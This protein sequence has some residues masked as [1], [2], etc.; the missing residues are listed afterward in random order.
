[1]TPA[2]KAFIQLMIVLLIWASSFTITRSVVKDVPPI[3]FALLRYSVASIVMVCIYYSQRSKIKPPATKMHG[4][5]LLMAL[6]GISLYY[7]FFNISL[8]HTEAS[9]GALI[10]GFIPVVVM[11]LAY[12][13]LKEK[14]SLRQV[15]GSVICLAGVILIGFI[16]PGK[17][18]GNSLFGNLLMIAAVIC[19]AVYTILS[20]RVAQT[21]SIWLTTRLTVIGTILL[22]PAV[23]IEMW[24]QPLPQI[25]AT[26]WAA[27]I[28]MGIF[29]SAISYLWYNNALKH[30]S[31][32]RVGLLLNLD[33][34]FGA[35]LAVVV[36][37]EPLYSLQIVGA[38]LVFAGILLSSSKKSA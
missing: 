29:P 27:I 9:V 15:F 11:I 3:L 1:M 16:S 5:V 33:P 21:D 17:S 35:V 37:N 23:L 28:Y 20:K 34:V 10:Q 7:I 14:I 18:G 2:K 25:G 12:V 26:G 30:I 6:S 36:L 8:A 4:Q 38:V 24:R 13:F 32:T 31:A 19:W 22:L